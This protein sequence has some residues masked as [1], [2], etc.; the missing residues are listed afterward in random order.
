MHGQSRISDFRQLTT[1]FFIHLH[2]QVGAT[3][4]DLV[5]NSTI[6]LEVF[7]QCRE[8]HES[9]VIRTNLR[10]A[11]IKEVSVRILIASGARE[12]SSLVYYPD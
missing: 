3:V 8:C 5:I 2:W 12:S 10:L 7:K 1:I 11:V 6:N 4:A 9:D